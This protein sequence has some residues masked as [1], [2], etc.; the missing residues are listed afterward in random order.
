M[1]RIHPCNPAQIELTNRYLRHVNTV[2]QASDTYLL[3]SI[4]TTIAASN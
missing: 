3:D 2:I 4:G 1:P